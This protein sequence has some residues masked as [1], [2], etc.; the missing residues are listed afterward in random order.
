MGDS[1][2]TNR[3]S[4]FHRILAALATLVPANRAVAR[5]MLCFVRVRRQGRA[6]GTRP[7][8]RVTREGD[9]SM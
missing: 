8:R 9:V 3:K 2:R 5:G 7:P 6:R 4:R 1:P